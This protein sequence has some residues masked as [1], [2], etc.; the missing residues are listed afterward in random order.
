MSASVHLR[1][2]PGVASAYWGIMGDVDSVPAGFEYQTIIYYSQHGINKAFEG[3]GQTLRKWYGKPDLRAQD[4]T[5]NYIGYWMDYGSF[6]YDNP[7]DNS[8][9]EQTILEVQKNLKQQKT[10]VNYFQLD[11]W[12]Y[13][14]EE[15]QTTVITWDADVNAIP[16]GMRKFQD[17][18]RNKLAAQCGVWSANTTY[19]KINGGNFTFLVEGDTA[20]PKQSEFWNY[21][22]STAQQWGLSL[23]QQDWM[24]KQSELM[25][26]FKTD[27]HVA[28]QWLV[29]MGAA[30]KYNIA[31]Q[32]SG[33]LPRHALQSVEV[34]SVTQVRVSAD[35]MKDADQWKIGVTSILAD[36]LGLAPFKDT[37][38]SN[39]TESGNPQYSREPA[40]IRQQIVATLSTGPVAIGDKLSS[41]KH[42]MNCCN[43]N[44]LILK[45]SRP[46]TAIDAQLIQAA[47][48]DGS[49]PEGE[50]W[51]TYSQIGP[52]KFGLIFAANL[53]GNYSLGQTAAFGR[54]YPVSRLFYMEQ[55]AFQFE[56]SDRKP[57]TLCCTDD[58]PYYLLFYTTP[59]IRFKNVEVLLL[60]E[61]FKWVPMSPR[62]VSDIS[63][64]SDSIKVAL[65]GKPGEQLTFIYSVNSDT[66]YQRVTIGTGGTTVLVLNTTAPATTTASPVTRLTTE[67]D[68]KRVTASFA[69]IM[70]I[71]L[72]V[73]NQV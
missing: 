42:T 49:G 67:S 5:L 45:P 69:L 18:L 70:L 4:S 15:N 10:S 68:A 38:W 46:A 35:Y 12:W 32:Y 63:V 37:F 2:S 36:A 33:A 72:T 31:I 9:Y 14:K 11:D 1:K 7:L 30:R 56:F 19:A 20:L 52:F 26:V 25:S 40:P 58:W 61:H 55:P 8:T 21:L 6:Y 71:I 51:T 64:L 29:D 57:V 47:F 39:E 3:W 60:G 54:H 50:V 59:V 24:R 28:R 62:R 65:A 48:Q 53:T 73:T 27:L 41:L 22:F 44:G 34:P 43:A 13:V 16:S 23:F 66:R 17:A